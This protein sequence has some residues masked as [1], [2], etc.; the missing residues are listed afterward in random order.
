M[1][2]IRA[3]IQVAQPLADA[4]RHFTQGIDRWWPPLGRGDGAPQVI[5]EAEVGGRWYERDADGRES[6]WGPVLAWTAPEALVLG[7][8]IGADGDFD[9][10][11]ATEVEVR[12]AAASASATLVT[13][14]HR[15]LER[16]GAAAAA[17]E[18]VLSSAVG[19]IGILERFAQHCA[20]GFGAAR[21]AVPSALKGGAG[22]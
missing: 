18:A 6:V 9:V 16:Y 21:R 22:A 19:W 5:I 2:K 17:Q 1:T 8:Q 20:V 13:L 4:F 15:H 12:F 10:A 7:W 3:S 11:L 14:E